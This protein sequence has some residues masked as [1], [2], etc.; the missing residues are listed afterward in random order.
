MRNKKTKIHFIGIG[1]IG[2]SALAQYYLSQGA[3][4]SGTDLVSSEITKM[5]ERKGAK[6]FINSK[7]KSQKSKPQLKTQNLIKNSDL[8]IYSKAV[9]HSHPELKLARKLKKKCLSYPEALGELTKQ[10]FT[11]AVCGTHG[12]STTTA[13]IALML[14]KAG[15]NPTVILGTKLKEFENSNFRMG[16]KPKLLTTHYLLPTDKVLIIE[17]DEHFSSFLNYWPRIIVLT[18]IEKDHLDY[19]RNLKNLLRAFEQFIGHLKKDGWLIFNQD[20]KGISKLKIQKSK[21]QLKT[22]SFS[23][24]QKEAKQLKN[25][26]KVPGKHNLYNAL[27]SYTCAKTLGV[28]E[29]IILEA[30][31]EYKGAWRRLE[32]REINL[33]N[34]KALLISDYGHHPTEIRATIEAIREKY[35]NRKIWLVFQ[36]HQY[37]RT[38]YLWKDF[39]KTLREIKVEKI[40]LL[41]IYEVAGREKKLSQRKIS[42]NIL[43]QKINER[44]KKAVFAKDFWE[45]KDYIT[46]NFKG[47]ILVIMG[48][49][50]IYNLVNILNPEL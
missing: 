33:N 20:D 43:V 13:M 11:I 46:K 50:D 38:F 47:E 17:A 1:G 41:P 6:I 9:P 23:L 14:M 36:P 12:K 15:L 5:L 30:L 49:G 37:Q 39:I 28:S 42:S 8:V 26:L 19:Y 44:S 16:G 2:V 35:P 3:E 32:E 4:V 10:Y 48:A 29:K 34:R 24:K 31:S 45:A 40:I 25:I 27:A 21:L 7:G 22:Q 18:N